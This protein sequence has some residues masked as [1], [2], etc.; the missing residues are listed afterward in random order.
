MPVKSLTPE[1]A[2]KKF[3]GGNSV[4]LDVRTQGEVDA[5]ALKDS[6]HLDSREFDIRYKELDHLRQQNILVF[7]KSGGRSGDVAQ[8]LTN[9]GF[10]NVFNVGGYEDLTKYF[11]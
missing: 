5:G 8:K 1:E 11:D 7:C 2:K 3:S 10:P 9:L 4:L 6:L